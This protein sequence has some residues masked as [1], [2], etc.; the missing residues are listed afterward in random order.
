M[1]GKDRAKKPNK[2]QKSRLLINVKNT[3]LHDSWRRSPLF[4][5]YVKAFRLSRLNIECVRIEQQRFVVSGGSC[6]VRAILALK[7]IENAIFSLFAGA[8]RMLELKR[9]M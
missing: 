8:S 2:W 7:T 4:L 5:Q 9:G 3:L 1:R 6:F